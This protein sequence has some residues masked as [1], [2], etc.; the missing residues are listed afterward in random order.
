MPPV[1][2]DL[3]QGY[4][5]AINTS[6][7]RQ[8]PT[9]ESS[10]PF[11]TLLTNPPRFSMAFSN[12]D[13]DLEIE[14]EADAQSHD[15]HPT[16]HHN[17]LTPVSSRSKYGNLDWD[18]YKEEIRSLYLEENQSLNNTMRIMKERHSFPESYVYTLLQYDSAR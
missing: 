16:G 17:I 5:N 6:D 11:H 12:D 1:S 13:Y 18:S 3:F 10:D 9:L 15:Q 4:R 14:E 7:L 2:P 8:S